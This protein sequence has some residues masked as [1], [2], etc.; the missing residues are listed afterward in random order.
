MPAPVVTVTSTVPAAPAGLVAVIWVS[1]TTVKIAG[2]LPKLTAV[3]PVKP[4]PMIVTAVPPPASPRAG[5][6]PVTR[7]TADNVDS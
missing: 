1:E 4:V 6:S 3:T 7:G 2:L 5:S